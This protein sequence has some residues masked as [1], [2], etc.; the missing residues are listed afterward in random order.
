MFY[1]HCNSESVLKSNSLAAEIP[2]QAKMGKRFTFKALVLK[3]FKIVVKKGGD[4]TQW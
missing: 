4:A 2:Q 1:T 3:C